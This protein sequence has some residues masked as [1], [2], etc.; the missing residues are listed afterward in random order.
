MPQGIPVTGHP[1]RFHSADPW[2][3]QVQ[4]RGSGDPRLWHGDVAEVEPAWRV[5]PQRPPQILPGDVGGAVDTEP[6]GD[7]LAAGLDGR[8]QERGLR[9]DN[10][11]DRSQRWQRVIDAGAI[12][13]TWPPIVDGRR[14]LE[15]QGGELQ[16]P[17]ATRDREQFPRDGGQAGRWSDPQPYG[18]TR[19][20]HVL[21][22][23]RRNDET[24][25]RLAQG[26]F[27]GA[28]REGTMQGSL[29]MAGPD[30]LTGHRVWQGGR[31][32]CDEGRQG[33]LA[34]PV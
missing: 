10:G 3:G 7:Q 20:R 22:D 32:L 17:L 30:H 6:P 29:D 26:A 5:G 9:G 1:E 21:P 2:V 23:R 12:W 24:A 25:E 8:S 34:N 11:I 28:L 27:A 19:H 14:Q 4:P 13:S 18:S 16:Q 31:Q 15:R 33:P